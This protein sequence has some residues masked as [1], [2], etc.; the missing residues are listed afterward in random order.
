MKVDRG[1]GKHH[2]LIQL[3]ELS[4]SG[5]KGDRRQTCDVLVTKSHCNDRVAGLSRNIT[6][7]G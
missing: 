4:K 7:G 6:H 3:A 2:S 5:F 1:I